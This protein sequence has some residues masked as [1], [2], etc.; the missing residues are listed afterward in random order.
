MSR[1]WYLILAD[2]LLT[3][4]AVVFGLMLRL[5]V[6]YIGVPLFGYFLRQIWPFILFAVL[7]R[8]LVFYAF[9]IYRRIWRYAAP[10][11][12]LLL[13]AAVLAGSVILALV[14]FLWLYPRYMT[15]F[16]RSLLVLEG[17]ISLFLLGG[18]RVLFMLT[19]HYPGDIDWGSLKLP[20]PR[21]ALVVG[22]GSAGAQM[23][24]EL[25]G[26]P[27]FG[28]KPVALLDDDPKKVG[29]KIHGCT[30]Y[31]PLVN[32]S[33]VVRHQQIDEVVIAMPSAPQQTLQGIKAACQELKV[34]FSTMPSLGGL[35]LDS[36]SGPDGDDASR[37]GLR[38]P[39][40]L[41]DITGREIEA[42]VRVL[43]SRNLSFGSQI[44]EFEKLA[45]VEANAEHAVAV[46]NGTAALHLCMAAAGIGPGDEVITTPYS[47]IASS[48][49]ILYQGATPVFVDIDPRT[50]NID[51]LRIEA[52]V[53]ER[54]R[55][56]LPVHLFGQ[57]ADMDPILEIAG[58]HDLLVI[59]DAC[60]AVGAEY[61][62]RR[63]G[64]L[65]VAGAF[66]FYPNKQMTTGEGAVLVTNDEAWAEL[67]R[68]LRNQGRD[69]FDEWLDHS[70]LG[71]NYRMSD[72]N[73]AVGV[74]QMRRLDELLARREA[75]TG[76]YRRRLARIDKVAPLEIVPTTTRMSW[77]IY[78][79][80]FDPDV[81]R[82]KVLSLLAERGIPARPYFSPIHLQPFYRQRFGFQPGDFPESEKAGRSYLALPFYTAMPPEE[83]AAVCKALEE[84]VQRAGVIANR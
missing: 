4:A 2:A 79:V 14:T 73:A 61:K 30:V 51:P 18:L 68:S 16:P 80:R 36:S 55:A 66:A 69:R 28:L 46:I 50:L 62:G 63:V 19:E 38:V 22:A 70:R 9:G 8:P 81:D 52:A 82:N 40:A 64:A 45:A 48:N 20:P 56:I 42:V 23:M 5:E 1:I 41:P 24:R 57:P 32:L 65:G 74:V 67:F 60:E 59:E 71:Y 29:R 7:L 26:N 58:R 10:R 3:L 49:V 15:T 44:V 6:F 21:R 34:P 75:V 47:F 25:L 83:V 33:D 11:D 35:L 13:G 77:F 17:G 37:P 76:E 31:G 27:M 53:T 43:Q 12:F 54:T 78:P 72:L 39:M 84:A